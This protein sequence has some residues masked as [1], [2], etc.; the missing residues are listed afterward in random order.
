MSLHCIIW[1]CMVLYCWLRRA[2]CI[3]QDTYLLYIHIFVILWCLYIYLWR[4]GYE[5]Q[6][7]AA[8]PPIIMS[9]AAQKSSWRRRHSWILSNS[10]LLVF[11]QIFYEW[12][13]GWAFYSLRWLQKFEQAR[14]RKSVAFWRGFPCAGLTLDGKV[15]LSGSTHQTDSA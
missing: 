1:C 3:S 11:V 2:G 13:F 8:V 6:A 9:I 10:L 5:E 7:A 4:G 15:P 14:I 12:F